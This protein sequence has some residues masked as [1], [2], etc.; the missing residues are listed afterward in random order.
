MTQEEV[1]NKV[2]EDAINEKDAINMD[3]II[4]HMPM[5]PSPKKYNS[6]YKVGD[7]VKVKDIK[8]YKRNHDIYGCVIIDNKYIM[9]FSDREMCGK[10]FTIKEV[11]GDD[12]Y[13]FVETGYHGWLE[14][15]IECKVEE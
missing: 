9:K 4:T 6:R 13:T 5:E 15:I 12:F 1:Y 3:C 11:L 10:I 8:W 2:I 14:E 7:K